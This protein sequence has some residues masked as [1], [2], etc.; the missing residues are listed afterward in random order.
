MCCRYYGNQQRAK[1]YEGFLS[2]LGVKIND[3][4][5]DADIQSLTER[6]KGENKSLLIVIREN[7]IRV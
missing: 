2:G 4:G 5:K 7:K 6:V 1:D 3:C